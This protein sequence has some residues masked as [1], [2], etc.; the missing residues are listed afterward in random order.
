MDAITEKAEKVILSQKTQDDLYGWIGPGEK[1]GVCHMLV[2]E[3]RLKWV[4]VKSDEEQSI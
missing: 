3:N 4:E 1:M 2:N